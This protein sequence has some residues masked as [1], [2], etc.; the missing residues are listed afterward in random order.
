MPQDTPTLPTSGTFA[1][2]Q[3][4][5]PVA[6]HQ[7]A[8]QRIEHT[9]Q[10][11]KGY[12]LKKRRR[13]PWVLLAIIIVAGIA[14]AAAKPKDST[15]ATSSGTPQPATPLI[16]APDVATGAPLGIGGTD[17]T[18]GFQV[19]LIAV[20]DPWV[21][22]SEFEH[23]SA[24][25]RYVAV[26]LSMVN[27]TADTQTFSSLLGLEVVDSLGQHWRPTFAG[28]NLPQVDGTLAPGAMIRGSQ[29]FEVPVA[30]TGL[31]LVVTGSLTATGITFTL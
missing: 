3:L 6:Y 16:D 5:P 10:P 19:T 2:P 11:P 31:A 7:L 21:S 20:T 26:E 9:F 18:S 17:T 12:K 23:P 13:W 8:P 25:N 22:T 24:G 4:P 15:P 29:V 27:T 30:S 1:P 28:V 14:S